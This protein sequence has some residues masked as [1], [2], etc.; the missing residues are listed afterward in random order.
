[1]IH[2]RAV[3]TTDFATLDGPDQT[4]TTLAASPAPPPSSGAIASPT[5]PPSS[6]AVASLAAGTATVTRGIAAI[7]LAC[8][9]AGGQ[10]CHGRLQ[11]TVRER[12]ITGR[13][14]HR[15][16]TTTTVSLG[17]AGLDL[18][19]GGHAAVDARLDQRGDALLAAARG[20]RLRI[21]VRIALDEGAPTVT[22]TVELVRDRTRG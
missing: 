16:V 18:A 19:A 10:R 15:R 22:A 1:M 21:T 2:Y 17:S 20:H 13:A 8:H 5:P 9:G 14:Q 11:L 6:H 3:A 7:K 12:R 4:L